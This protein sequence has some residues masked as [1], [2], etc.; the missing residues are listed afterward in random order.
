MKKNYVFLEILD[1]EEEP[2]KQVVVENQE[3]DNG[4]ATR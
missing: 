3:K 1:C 4:G 2:K